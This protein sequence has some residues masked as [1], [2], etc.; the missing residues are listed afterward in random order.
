MKLV[1]ISAIAFYLAIIIGCGK[2]PVDQK[3][4]K[5]SNAKEVIDK[6]KAKRIIT[7]FVNKEL[8][9][10]EYNSIGAQ[11]HK[12]PKFDE[13]FWMSVD[14]EEDRWVARHTAGATAGF[15]VVASVD[16]YGQN[17]KLEEVGFSPD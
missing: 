12:Y 17:P 10:K 16:K 5:Q 7:E 4:P 11:M 2:Q 9:D 8:K 14:Y 6:N 3:N 15:Y 13:N 1:F